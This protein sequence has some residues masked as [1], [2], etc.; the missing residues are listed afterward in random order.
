MIKR[1]SMGKSSISKVLSKRQY[2]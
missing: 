1:R 2:Y